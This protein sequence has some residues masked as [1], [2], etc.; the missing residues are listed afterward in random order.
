MPN[1]SIIISPFSIGD[2]VY[3]TDSLEKTVREGR[4][5]SFSYWTNGKD[6]RVSIG[7]TGTVGLH[8][9][10]NVFFTRAEAEQ[11]LAEYK[12]IWRNNEKIDRSALD[13]EQRKS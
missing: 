8:F 1:K 10:H 4:I 7:C 2:T 5:T 11:R 12:K 13:K 9:G 6:E 3:Y